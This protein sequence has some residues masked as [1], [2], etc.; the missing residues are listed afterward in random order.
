MR[1][2]LRPIFLQWLVFP[3]VHNGFKSDH[4]RRQWNLVNPEYELRY[5]ELR[6][7][8]RQMLDAE[9]QGGWGSGK[10]ADVTTQDNVRP[11]LPNCCPDRNDGLTRRFVGS[12][13][14]AGSLLSLDL[15]TFFFSTSV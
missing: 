6:A 12:S 5:L 10:L 9:R 2:D 1:A 13:R 15:R 3:S 4:C 11:S 14:S 8:D 7:F